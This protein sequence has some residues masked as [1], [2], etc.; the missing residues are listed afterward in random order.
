MLL[1][2]TFLGCQVCWL[3]SSENGLVNSSLLLTLQWAYWHIVTSHL[4]MK[5]VVLWQSPVAYAVCSWKKHLCKTIRA[6]KSKGK[7]K[8]MLEC[9]HSRFL[10]DLC[11]SQIAW[12]W[13]ADTF[14]FCLTFYMLPEEIG[15]RL[16]FY[17][18]L[19]WERTTTAF[20]KL[21]LFFFQRLRCKCCRLSVQRSKLKAPLKQNVML[22]LWYAVFT[23][24]V[25]EDFKGMFTSIIH[26]PLWIWRS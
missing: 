23:D 25:K 2:E 5:F 19:P 7:G 20:N 3:F 21:N 12:H 17:W 10:S 13:I 6:L 4:A 9:S 1:L 26:K 18:H 11:S 14:L 16:C 24:I 8:Q 15:R 22:L